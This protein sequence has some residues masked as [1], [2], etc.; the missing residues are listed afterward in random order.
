MNKPG[1]IKRRLIKFKELSACLMNDVEREVKAL[2]HASRDSLRNQ[3]KD[4]KKITFS[5]N[6]TY[7]G[8]ALG[9]FKGLYL[10]GYGY[11]GPT[12]LNAFE[13]TTLLICQVSI[14]SLLL[15]VTDRRQNL[16]WWR[17]SLKQ[18]VLKEEN[19]K[20]NG[21]CEYCLKRYKK[22]DSKALF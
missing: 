2:L 19:F 8:E 5:V 6:N 17:A 1:H 7:Y 16:S 10:L 18:E 15:K 3:K 12:N 13:D 22:D 21:R 14:P 20:G 11:Y 9:I 4:T